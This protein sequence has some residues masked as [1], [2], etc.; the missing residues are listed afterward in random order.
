[1]V[2]FALLT[3]ML[4]N[5]SYGG[6]QRWCQ[7]LSILPPPPRCL[8]VLMWR[9]PCVDIGPPFHKNIYFF[10]V[11]QPF[12]S[13]DWLLGVYSVICI[14]SR[15][16]SLPPPVSLLATSL[17]IPQ[18]AATSK[19]RQQQGLFFAQLH[20]IWVVL[21]KFYGISCLLLMSY[22]LGKLKLKFYVIL[23]RQIDM[24]GLIRWIRHNYLFL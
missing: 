20:T 6:R 1:M 15:D 10:R 12:D 2:A 23:Y 22:T 3:S 18:R 17:S 21:C 19:L 4:I 11:N 16:F 13:T 7:F 14:A 5:G 8:A 24:L 9:L